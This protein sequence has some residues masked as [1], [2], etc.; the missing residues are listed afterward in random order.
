MVLSEDLLQLIILLLFEK[1]S[2]ILLNFSILSCNVPFILEF[3]NAIL[4]TSLSGSICYLTTHLTFKKFYKQDYILPINNMTLKKSIETVIWPKKHGI[5]K[6][7]Q[8]EIDNTFCLRFG[9]SSDNHAEILKQALENESITNYQLIPSRSGN[10][11]IPSP[12]GQRY[13]VHGMGYA[14][15]SLLFK[16]V[17]VYD[18]SFDYKMGISEEHLKLIEPL[19]TKWQVE[20]R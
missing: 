9:P 16:K 2:S 6:V 4:S 7:I 8:L 5:H 18:N 14:L 12:L 11:Q 3:S 15:V 10:Y 17:R 20:L 19:I 13:K 1:K